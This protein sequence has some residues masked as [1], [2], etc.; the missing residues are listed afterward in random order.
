LIRPAR[1][2]LHDVRRG[3]PRDLRVRRARARA[4]H[5]PPRGHTRRPYKPP[6]AQAQPRLQAAAPSTLWYCCAS[7]TL[8][9]PRLAVMTA[10]FA[11]IKTQRTPHA[12]KPMLHCCMMSR[13][14]FASCAEA[15]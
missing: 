7:E 14:A 3:V 13:F 12:E 15:V 5:A 1:T 8:G 10:Y 11:N 6:P 4:G 2:C 9:L